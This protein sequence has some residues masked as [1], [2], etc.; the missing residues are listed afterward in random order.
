VAAGRLPRELRQQRHLRRLDGLTLL[1]G[2]KGRL[3]RCEPAPRAAASAPSCQERSLLRNERWSTSALESEVA[4]TDE[5]PDR[6]RI[7][8]SRT[9]LPRPC[10]AY[11]SSGAGVEA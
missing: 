4:S 8:A 9:R 7:R 11:N 3:A 10:C 1:Q 6:R 2:G 5:R